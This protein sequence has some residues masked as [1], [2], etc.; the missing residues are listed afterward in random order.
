MPQA[1]NNPLFTAADLT[2]LLHEPVSEDAAATAEL[3]V[4]GWVS[5]LLIAQGILARPSDWTDL[6]WLQGYTLELGGIAYRN[7]TTDLQHIDGP[8]EKK[9][10]NTRRDEILAAI[11]NGGVP[12]DPDSPPSPRGR[13]PRAHRYPDPARPVRRVEYYG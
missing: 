12:V 13:F 6:E 1:P 2:N 4:W 8:F 7:P 9:F 10:E 3:V 5:P 11:R